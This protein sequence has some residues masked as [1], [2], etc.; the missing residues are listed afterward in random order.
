LDWWED[1]INYFLIQINSENA[2]IRATS[3]D[4]ISN[5][6]ETIFE[7]MNK[8]KQIPCITIP[9]NHSQNDKNSNVR[10]AACRTLGTLITYRFLSNDTMFIIDVASTIQD[11]IKDN[12]LIV[13]IRSSWLY[14][15][16]CDNLILMNENQESHSILNEWLDD[17]MIK[18]LLES[19]ISAAKDNDKVK[20]YRFYY[21]YYYYYY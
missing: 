19:G 9:L 16:F 20:Y 21:Y 3:C 17:A 10:A 14:G 5:I 11:T 15:N 2:I 6:P 4:C 12:N 13:R 1:I 8:L 7:Q 18:K